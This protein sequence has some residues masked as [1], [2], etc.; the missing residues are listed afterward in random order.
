V[1]SQY[2][3]VILDNDGRLVVAAH[4]V[5]FT[6]PWINAEATPNTSGNYSTWQLIG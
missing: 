3:T 6:R 2:P 4:A 1:G 5:Q